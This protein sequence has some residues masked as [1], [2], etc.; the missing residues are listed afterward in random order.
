MKFDTGVDFMNNL[1][2]APGQKKIL[3]KTRASKKFDL[4]S[5]E[6]RLANLKDMTSGS[7]KASCTRLGTKL[8]AL[9]DESNKLGKKAQ[10]IERQID[11]L[12]ERIMRE[13]DV[14]DSSKKPKPKK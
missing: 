7:K 2:L 12:A 6:K 3:K 5:I 14:C 13:G 10:A 1:P 4:A 8:A 11:A 9:I